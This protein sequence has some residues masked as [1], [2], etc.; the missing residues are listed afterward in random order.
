MVILENQALT[1]TR[2]GTPQINSYHRDTLL[3]IPPWSQWPLDTN[4]WTFITSFWTLE[5]ITN[6]FKISTEPSICIISIWSYR[7]QGQK[8]NKSHFGN[9]PWWMARY[10]HPSFF[11]WSPKKNWVSMLGNWWMSTHTP[12]GSIKTVKTV[13]D[14]IFGGSKITAD[15]DAAMKLKDAYSLEGKLCLT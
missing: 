5:M 2:E 1:R 12:Y 13:S 9:K 6:I 10:Y 15:G 11:R 7:G 3:I 8:G 4:L 14:F